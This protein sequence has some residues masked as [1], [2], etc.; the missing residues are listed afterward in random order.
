VIFV[1]SDRSQQ[2]QESYLRVM[3]NI[4]FLSHGVP[5]TFYFLPY[6]FLG[7]SDPYSL[8]PDP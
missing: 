7:S 4:K 6:L 5:K 1:S 3:K 2:E 8:K